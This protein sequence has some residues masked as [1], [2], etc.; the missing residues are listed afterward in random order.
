MKAIMCDGME[1][2][3]IDKASTQI[4][5]N[6]SLGAFTNYVDKILPITNNLSNPVCICEG[7][8]LL[9]CTLSAKDRGATKNPAVAL[10]IILV[11]LDLS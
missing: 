9:K 7:I 3:H 2:V 5:L 11:H 10:E 6:S 8:A 1:P 4:N